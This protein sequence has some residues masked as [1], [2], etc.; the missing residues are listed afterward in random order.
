MGTYVMSDL[1]G[2]FTAFQEMLEK[3]GFNKNDR[4]IIAGDMIDR[5]P[6][7]LEMLK[8][9]EKK[10]ENVEILMGNHE[11]DFA[12]EYVPEILARTEPFGAGFSSKLR[13]IDPYYDPYGTI[14]E[15]K[16]KGVVPGRL[17]YWAK[18][19][20]DFPY[21]KMLTVNEKRY[22][23][24]HASYIS[25]E[26]YKKLYGTQKGLEHE[27]IWN[28]FAFMYD[29]GKGD[30]I[31]FGHTPTIANEGYFA[32]GNIFKEEYNGNRFI[33]IDCGYVHRDTFP[34]GKMAA[35]R[36]EDEAEFYVGE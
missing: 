25:P 4:L 9:M 10:P 28:R 21:Y 13:Y 22:I 26:K 32:D 12:Y 1:H 20:R 24:V 29:E 3:I 18:L 34:N 16:K 6:E 14:R 30:T 35:I 2:C 33:N 5:G 31:V 11:Y 8:W 7:N 15:L 17:E 23:I 27:Y 19:M 36:L